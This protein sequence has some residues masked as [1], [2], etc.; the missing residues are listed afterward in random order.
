M[1][2]T[3]LAEENVRNW[4]I[5]TASDIHAGSGRDTTQEEEGVGFIG[6]GM[7]NNKTNKHNSIP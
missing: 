1:P 5:A 4:L 7:Y 6:Y 2:C 3:T